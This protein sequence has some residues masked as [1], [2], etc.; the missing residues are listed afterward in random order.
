MLG[1]ALSIAS[2]L[3]LAWQAEKLN[4]WWF[5]VLLMLIGL[6]FGG[7]PPLASTV[8]QNTVAIQNFGTAVGTMQFSRGLFG[9]I[10]VALF[11]TLVLI[12]TTVL[13]PDATVDISPSEI[14]NAEGF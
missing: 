6:G 11:G 1:L 8:L 14:Y 13:S 3:V 9:T 12:G 5:E 7:V 10:L 2:V 4:L